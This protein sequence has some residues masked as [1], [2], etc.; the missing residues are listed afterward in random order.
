[1]ASCG[2]LAITQKK[3][4]RLS[5]PFLIFEFEA[6]DQRLENWAAARAGA[7]YFLRSTTPAVARQEAALLHGAAQI[8]LVLGKRWE[9]RG[10]PR[11]PGP[12]DRRPRRVAITSNCSRRCVTSNG[13]WRPSAAW[14]A[15][16]DL[17]VAAV[18]GDLARGRA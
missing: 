8:R 4:G 10:A 6:L 9:M 11:G 15:Q 16:V 7:P 18:D 5:A 17:L 14:A 3:E 13:C 2:Q 12:T 1:M